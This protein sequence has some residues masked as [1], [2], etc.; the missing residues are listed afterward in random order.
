MAPDRIRVAIVGLGNVGR[1]VLSI[2]DDKQDFFRERHGLEFVVVGA[3]DSRGAAC[4]PEGLNLKRV[5]GLK[6][7]RDTVASYIGVGQAGMTGLQMLAKASADVLIEASPVNLKDGEPGMGH[8]RMALEKGMHVVTAN[9]GPLALAYPEV[10]AVAREQGRRVMFSATAGGGLP[11]VNIGV[12]DLCHARIDRVEGVLNFTSHFI[13]THMGKGRTYPE[14][15]QR[16]QQAGHAE[17]DPT[18]DVEGWDAANKLV[19]LANSVLRYPARLSDVR[20]AGIQGISMKML[21]HARGRG[22]A[23]LPLAVAE[24]AG[25]GYRLSVQPTEVGG[26]HPLAHL[27]GDQMGIV[28]HTDTNGVVTA[29]VD[30]VDPMPTAGAVVRDLINL[31]R[32]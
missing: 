22:N 8:I 31:Y 24:R 27:T 25:D 11:S 13:L 5:I 4:D 18:L 7:M 2:L 20:I 17:A 32:G 26:D 12:R 10:M 9:K 19:I 23:I 14:A 29:I 21:K 30:E 15:L 6:E 16:A 3:A 1:R 28:Y